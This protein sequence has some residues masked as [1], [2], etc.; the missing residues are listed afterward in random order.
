MSEATSF[1]KKPLPLPHG[2]WKVHQSI[3]QYL[4][5]S[6]VATFLHYCSCQIYEINSLLEPEM[7]Y[8]LLLLRMYLTES[9]TLHLFH[10][11]VLNFYYVQ[12]TMGH[13]NMSMT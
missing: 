4:L 5:R 6:D 9:W 7:K 10:K 8:F 13:I 2:N 1:T 3:N 11:Y 12:G